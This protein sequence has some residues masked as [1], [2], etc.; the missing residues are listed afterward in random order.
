VQPLGKWQLEQQE[1]DDSL[2]LKLGTKDGFE[3][4]FALNEEHAGSLGAA[5]LET[6]RDTD[7]PLV[8]R[9]N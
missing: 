5:L 6:P 1:I 3:V 9:P 7:P 2:I 4:A 8:R